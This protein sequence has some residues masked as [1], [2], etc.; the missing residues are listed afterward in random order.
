MAK[1][2]RSH[3]ALLSI[4]CAAFLIGGIQ[5]RTLKASVLRAVAL[6]PAPQDKPEVKTFSG[7]VL[8]QNGEQYILRDEANDVW[9][10]LDD[11][12]QAE[13]FFGKNVEVKG[14]L[15]PRTDTIRIHEITETKA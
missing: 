13:K 4:F 2:M 7:K 15:D 8:S 5:A 1:A 11:Q 10:H 14:V 12:K 6:Q 9:Y 3:V